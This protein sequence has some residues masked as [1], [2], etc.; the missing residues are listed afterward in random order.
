MKITKTNSNKK[1]FIALAIGLILL[2]SGAGVAYALV[3]QNTQ[4]EETEKVNDVDYEPATDQQIED[5]TTIKEQ[6]V[7]NADQEP[8]DTL[9][10]TL[11]SFKK[12]PTTYHVGVDIA[13]VLSTGTCT[14]TLTPV[15]SG[16]PMTLTADIQPLAGYS[17][18]KGFDIL[19]SELNNQNWTIDAA[20]TSGDLTGSANGTIE[21]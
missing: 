12:N 21:L 4:T 3:Q 11:T 9:S 16:E 19:V 6:T 10:L 2:V 20:V 14:I 15:G 1:L 13:Q 18:C 5:G 17:T 8:A 7:E